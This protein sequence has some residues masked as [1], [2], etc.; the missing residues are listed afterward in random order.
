MQQLGRAFPAAALAAL[1]PLTSWAQ[2]AAGSSSTAPRPADRAGA[3]AV[4][5]AV[6]AGTPPVI[7]GKLDDA[8]WAAAPAIDTFTQRDPQEGMPVSERTE[9]RIAYD[10][11]AVYIAGR[12]FDRSPI[13]TRLGRRDMATSSSD[14]F[15]I[16]IDSFYDRRTAFVFEVNPSGV[17]RDSIIAGRS[18]TGDLAWDAVWDAATSIDENGWTAEIRVPFS[19]LG[20]APAE[21]QTWG[22]QLARIINRRQEEAWFAFTPKSG[23][24][25]V[26]AYGDLTGLRGVEP[27]RRLELLPYAVGTSRRAGAPGALAGDRE[28]AMNAGLDSR[29]RLTSN[30]TLTATANPDFGQVEVDPAVIN[31]S[32]F[33][34]RYQERRPFFVEGAN[35]FKF[36]GAVGGPSA[37]AAG[38]LYSRRLGRAPQLPLANAADVPDTAT[39][40]GA[41]KLSGKTASGWNV[42]LLEA[43]TGSEFGEYRDG[44]GLSQ[45]AMVEPRTNYFIGR[46]SRDLRRGQSNIG[47]IVT[48]ANRDLA[49]DPRAD[50]LRA[51]AYTAGLDFI[52]EW[53]NRSW[54]VSG[55]LVGSHVGGSDAAIGATQRSST[56]YLQRPD[57]KRLTYD[58]TRTSL[59]GVAASV[60]MRKTA[61]LHWT[62]DSWLQTMS[63]GYEINDVGFQQRAD[64][65]AFGQ[66][67][68][69]SERRPGRIWRDWRSTTY[70]NR[71]KNFDG[72]V[73]DYFYWTSLTLTHLS[74]WQLTTSYWYEPKRTDDRLTRGGPLAM[75]PTTWRYNASLRSDPRKAI[76]GTAAF[77]LVA[78][79]AGSDNRT[80]SL[81]LDVRTSPRWNLSFGPELVQNRQHAQYVTAIRDPEMVSTF[82]TRYIF[83]PL[84][85]RQ[86]SIITRLNYTFTPN[87]TLEIYAQPLVSHGDYGLP[88]EFQSPSGYSFKT[89]G[90]DVGTIVRDGGRYVVDPDAGGPAAPFT[91]ADR[92]FTTRSL[93]GNAVLRWE[94]RPGSTLYLVWQQ[95]RL[96]EAAMSDFSVGRGFGS[97]F[98]GRANNV[99]VLKWSY[100]LNP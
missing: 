85:Q 56:R 45:R 17:R 5:A 64:R 43:V 33:E 12:F 11:E 54:V 15:S 10:A 47:G 26:P 19:Q 44:N 80:T 22:L 59:N 75:R 63:P 37:E 21:E 100:W 78:D 96:N 40:L 73:I 83:A 1:L 97:L 74:Y 88:K 4:A 30:L 57:A 46:T 77:A 82:G 65:R 58:A 99:V 81:S 50:G 27:G 60:N 95:D 42:G 36:G 71:A 51:E 90:E 62:T 6:R 28:L 70:V 23:Q 16:G 91:V 34:T 49:G 3:A 29:Y 79:Y 39:I 32:A 24:A 92:T 31:L 18:D 25:G 87:L 93:R 86:F 67:V 69:Y 2:A 98:D 66:G 35:A 20:F 68:T 7:D 55:F 84:D 94:Y 89:Y 53:A 41:V 72:N 8:A 48:A 14:W 13:T 52:H 38:V 61:G 76:T 9:V